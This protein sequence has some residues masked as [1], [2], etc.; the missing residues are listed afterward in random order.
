MLTQLSTEYT[1]W[2]QPFQEKE[3]LRSPTVQ[4]T[5]GIRSKT[6]HNELATHQKQPSLKSF[7]LCSSSYPAQQVVTVLLIAWLIVR[8]NTSLRRWEVETVVT[9]GDLPNFL[10]FVELVK[11]IQ[12]NHWD[13]MPRTPENWTVVSLSIVEA[14]DVGNKDK[15]FKGKGWLNIKG[16][17]K[18]LRNLTFQ[19]SFL[20]HVL[21]KNR[22]KCEERCISPMVAHA[23]NPKIRAAEIMRCQR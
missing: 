18:L 13:Y 2:A 11:A 19:N 4:L 6:C 12:K 23:N 22:V 8:Y 1:A 16:T 15:G 10:D 3:R 17:E 21:L 20:V 14:K 9:Q 7:S 5:R